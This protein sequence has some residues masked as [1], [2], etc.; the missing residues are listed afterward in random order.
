VKGEEREGEGGEGEEAKA[1][2]V[3]RGGAGREE[4]GREERRGEGRGGRGRGKERERRREKKAEG[5]FNYV[6]RFPGDL[7]VGT[8]KG[9]GKL[10]TVLSNLQNPQN[11]S[12]SESLAPIPFWEKV[13]T[14]LSYL[15]FE[16]RKI[17]FFILLLFYLWV[18]VVL[19]L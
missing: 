17:N 15:K 4:R 13:C 1:R 8:D 11:A 3:V 6:L 14:I 12:E 10:L 18:F 16:T 5:G 19:C 2:R 7:C 9:L